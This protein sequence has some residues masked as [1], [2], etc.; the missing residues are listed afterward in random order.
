V[1]PV[2]VDVTIDLPREEV[3]EYLADIANHPEFM[4]HFTSQWRLT[5]LDSY[6]EGAGARFHLD[7]RFH[8]FSWADISFVEVMP[9]FRI[10]G[11]GRGG[12]YNRNK[13]W[14]EWRL[15]PVSGGSTK[16]TFRAESEGA[17]PS[18]RIMEGFLYRAW[19]RR[20]AR[21]ALNRLLR[22]LEEGKDRGQRATV[23]GLSAPAG[24][25]EH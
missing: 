5:R 20:N 19:F 9:P 11:V 25:F 15:D 12:K 18:D 7:K 3:F 22:I 2:T 23:A 16:V 1:E 14:W 10:L 13:L 6:G 8:R 17:L 4:D 24:V 21:K